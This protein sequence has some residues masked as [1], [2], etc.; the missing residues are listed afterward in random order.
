MFIS[1]FIRRKKNATSLCSIISAFRLWPAD[2]LQ[3]ILRHD[4]KCMINELNVFLD[5]LAYNIIVQAG[6][7][8]VLFKKIIHVIFF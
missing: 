8:Y 7:Y 5:E 3:Y 6:K 2:Y 1:T 4:D